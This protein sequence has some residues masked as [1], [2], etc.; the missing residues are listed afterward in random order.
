MV[1]LHRD[2]AQAAM[3]GEETNYT[4]VEGWDVLIW[5]AL[6]QIWRDSLYF[7]IKTLIA[8]WTLMDFTQLWHTSYTWGIDVPSN[9]KV[10]SLYPLA[11]NVR[12]NKTMPGSE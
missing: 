7:K 8:F 11:G 6:P 12:E 1:D 10:V 4:S 2:E 3:E 9:K 5:P